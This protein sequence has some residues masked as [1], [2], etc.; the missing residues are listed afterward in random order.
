MGVIEVTVDPAGV[1]YIYHG[2]GPKPS[3]PVLPPPSSIAFANA[4][5]PLGRSKCLKSATHRRSF[6]ERSL[7]AY[8][9]VSVWFLP[10]VVVMLLLTQNRMRRCLFRFP[11]R[12]L[13]CP[14]E[15]VGEGEKAQPRYGLRH[16]VLWAHHHHRKRET[17]KISH[18]KL[19]VTHL[20]CRIGY[21]RSF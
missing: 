21:L 7:S 20:P 17:T 5:C 12:C 16:R 14:V 1:V 3:R 11:C 8:C 4:L 6:L 15:Q 2:C 13:L 18:Q 19:T 9:S 10:L